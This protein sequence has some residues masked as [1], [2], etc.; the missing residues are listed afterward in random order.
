MM[1]ADKERLGDEIAELA[2]HLDAAT[3]RLL[4]LIGEFDASGGWAD[5]GALTCA[6]WLG[7]RIGLELGAAREH[8]RVA[9]ALRD[10]PQIGDALRRG[11]VSY[12]KVRALTRVATPDTEAT[13]L[14]MARASTA[15]QLERICRGY[16]RATRD[17]D[18]RPEDEADERWLREG[19]TGTG[20][21]RFD[22]QLRTEEAA[23]LRRALEVATERAWTRDDVPAGTRAA[24]CRRTDAL[25]AVL[26]SYLAGDVDGAPPV[27]LVVHTDA[28]ATLDDGTALPPATGERLACD[29]TIVTVTEDSRGNVLDVGRRR[30]SIPTLLRRALRLRDR[31]C[32]FPGCTNRRVDGHH[33]VPWSRGG[34]TSLQNLV[35]LCR[36]HHGYVHEYGMRIV[37]DAAAAGLRFVRP[38][39]TVVSPYDARPEVAPDPA[40]VLQARNAGEGIDAMTAYP[41]WDGTPPDYGTIVWSLMPTA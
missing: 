2:A 38:N 15:S 20:F 14:A 23:L 41:R 32:R 26:E 7:W 40:A 12:S 24:Q 1:Y 34:P 22:I 27:E 4:V 10:L 5:Q 29:A 18:A 36:R 30:R 8:V 17:H 39:G 11:Q 35:S 33:V 19:D 13:L 25:M 16:R 9:R 6:H 21:V 3:H 31:G 37:T 28:G